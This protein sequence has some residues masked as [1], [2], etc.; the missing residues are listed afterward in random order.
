MLDS[1]NVKQDRGCCYMIIMYGVEEGTLKAMFVS[2]MRPRILSTTFLPSLV[3]T[4]I[5][6]RRLI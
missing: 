1:L 5:I 2:I 6:M 4:L 3:E